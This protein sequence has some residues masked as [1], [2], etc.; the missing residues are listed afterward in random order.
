MKSIIIKINTCTSEPRMAES[1]T[2]SQSL[3]RFQN[4]K[5]IKV[6]DQ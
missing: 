1:K 5:L 4:Q 6:V 3:L 2:G